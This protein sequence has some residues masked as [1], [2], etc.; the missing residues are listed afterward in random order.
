VRAIVKQCGFLG[1]RTC[2]FNR[3]DWPADPF[4]LGLS[5]HAY[6]HSASIQL[7]HALLERNFAGI[8]NYSTL[9]RLSH[10]WERHFTLA[11]DHVEAHGGIAH[12]YFH[13]WEIDQQRDWEKLRRVLKDASSRTGF[14]RVTNGDLFRL[15]AENRAAR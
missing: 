5:T 10:D 4:L 8:W 1:A 14:R 6:S 7:R 13:S 15:L 2:L 3:I 12:L 9:F 11:L